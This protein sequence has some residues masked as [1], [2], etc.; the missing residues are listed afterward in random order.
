MKIFH[1]KKQLFILLHLVFWFVSFNFWTVILNPG[2][3]S[4]TVIEGLEVDWDIILFLNFGYLLFC[5]L[6]LIWLF[7]KPRLWIKMTLSILF[8]I[9]LGYVIVQWISPNGSKDDVEVVVN[10]FVK[11]FLYVLV[12]H[13]TI[14][15]AVYF[16][17]KVLFTRFLGKS[18]FTPYLLYAIGLTIL[19][20]LL[21]YALF[22]LF[23]DPLFPSLYFISYFRIWELI[24]IVAAYLLFTSII[25]LIGQYALMLI[26]NRDAAR[27]ELSALKA[28]INPHFLFNNLNTIYSMAAQKDE[29]TPEV[30]LKLSDFLRYVLYDTGFETIPLEK[31]VEIIRTYISL[32]KERVQPEITQ[33][34]FTAEGNFTGAEISPLLLLPLAENCFKHGIG[35][36]LGTINIFI[37]FDG[38]ELLFKTANNIALR[39]NK[40][41]D[42]QGI[43]I[44][45]VEKRLN[46]IYPERHILRYQEKDGV[47]TLE[48]RIELR[49]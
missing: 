15:S 27:N 28:Q 35:K 3:E 44:N 16:N 20:A 47:F 48:M 39:E 17:L 36:N 9:P 40:N 14:I 43:G 13:L 24:L 5:S 46:L 12:F 23:I 29:R 22:D 11:N 49:K 41:E 45:N 38:K 34:V 6:P 21:N 33:I 25:F 1:L 42:N 26:A 31:E 18:Q 19:T 7:R 8:L 37:G 10:Y 4:A 32:Q 2:V 30:I